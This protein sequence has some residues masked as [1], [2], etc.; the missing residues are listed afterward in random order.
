M[1]SLLLALA[2]ILLLPAVAAA[3]NPA[4]GDPAVD[5]MDFTQWSSSTFC[6]GQTFAEEGADREK[7]ASDCFEREKRNIMFIT[8][9]MQEDGLN[10][11]HMDICMPIASKVQSFTVLTNCL[12]DM[13]AKEKE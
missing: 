2:F 4:P 5:P 11:K 9:L 6:L 1:R 13:E 3:Q 7:A 8:S 12:R 10:D